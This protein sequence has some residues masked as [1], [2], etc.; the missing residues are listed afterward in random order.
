[1]SLTETARRDTDDGD[2]STSPACS[3]RPDPWLFLPY[4]DLAALAPIALLTGMV[5]ALATPAGRWR[6]DWLFA[7]ALLA[8]VLVLVDDD[9]FGSR[10]SM[11]LSVMSIVLA[12]A[13]AVRARVAAR[14]G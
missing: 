8:G 2:R 10:E 4:S 5:A 6:A 13:C 11:L 14:T 9:P 12:E 7:L 1:V 3:A